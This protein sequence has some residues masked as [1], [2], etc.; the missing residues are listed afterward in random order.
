METILTEVV[1]V[2]WLSISAVAAGVVSVV[3]GV[4]ALMVSAIFFV[5]AKNS[6]QAISAALEGIRAQTNTLSE[7]SGK[8]LRDLTR[9]ISRQVQQP[10]QPSDTLKAFTEVMR[11]MREIDRGGLIQTNGQERSVS[12]VVIK[13]HGIPLL[14]NDVDRE[15]L[16]DSMLTAYF[17]IYYHSAYA[18]IFAQAYLP[19]ETDYQESEDLDRLVRQLLDLSA[20]DFTLV[21]NA[22]DKW[23]A[24]EPDFVRNHRLYQLFGLQGQDV[25]LLVRTA[26]QQF[27][28]LKESSSQ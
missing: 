17:A 12:G 28:N 4:V 3:L 7:I 27:D 14:Q 26:R 2:N 16:R 15:V 18:N 11:S 8:Q 1:P 9:V 22:L 21:A 20:Y 24:T 13:D 10:E 25:K 19:S 23:V 5:S 6:E